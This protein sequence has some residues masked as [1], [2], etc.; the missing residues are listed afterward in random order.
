MADLYDGCPWEI[1]TS[2]IPE[3]WADFDAS[4]REYATSLASSSL[5]ALTAGRVGGCPITVRPCKP[6]V[7]CLPAYGLYG[8]G[9]P[10]YSPGITAQ[11][12][13]I[14]SCGCETTCACAV[15][16][17]VDLPGPVG[18]VYAIK[19]DGV[20]Q[21]L[22]DFRL[23]N[24]TKVVYQG[25]LTLGCPFP[26]DQ[27]LRLPD[28][29]PGTWS[30]TYLNAVEPD[31]AASRAA[32]KLAYQFAL[33]CATSTTKAKCSLP[34]NV[35]SVVRTGVSLTLNTGVWPEGTTGIREIDSWIFL[36][37]PNG[38]R[39]QTRVLSLDTPEAYVQGNSLVPGVP[40]GTGPIVVDGG[41]P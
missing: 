40:T 41:A 13:W 15:S 32:A 34:A 37:N 1:D 10:L 16:C 27:D 12:L 4:V 36:Y 22:G 25:D 8:P 11:G 33:A 19:I 24:G 21:D 29:E 20:E 38:R 39:S 5:H 23:D 14:N 7:A 9:R 28:T 3:D 6:A 30:I 31:S 2:C 35:V 18:A 17:S 26:T